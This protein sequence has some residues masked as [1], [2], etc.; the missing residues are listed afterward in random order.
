[1]PSRNYRRNSNPF[2]RPNTRG[3]TGWVYVIS[4]V[5]MPGMVKV[6]FTLN[7]PDVRAKGLGHTG[8]PHPY[9]VDYCVQVVDPYSVE[10]RAHQI[11][12]E[13][14]HRV[15]EGRAAGQGIEWFSCEPEEA[16]VAIRHSTGDE[17]KHESF[18]RAEREIVEANYQ[19]EKARLGAMA[20]VAERRARIGSEFRGAVLTAFPS[21]PY[22]E[23]FITCYPVAFAALAFFSER[24]KTAQILFTSVF[25]GALAALILQIMRQDRH[26]KSPKYLA[27]KAKHD[28]DIETAN[29]HFFGCP[30][31]SASMKIDYV[32][33]FAEGN[34]IKFHCKSCG[35]DVANPLAPP[36]A[37]PAIETDSR[38]SAI[39]DP[40]SASVL[41]QEPHLSRKATK[42]AEHL[43]PADQA[44]LHMIESSLKRS[45]QM[46]YR[47]DKPADADRSNVAD[48][49]P[50][51]PAI[52]QPA[53]KSSPLRSALLLVWDSDV[54]NNTMRQDL[55][56]SFQAGLGVEL[57]TRIAVSEAQKERIARASNRI[58]ENRSAKYEKALWLELDDAVGAALPRERWWGR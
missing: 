34:R 47:H 30:N 55:W 45:A 2:H 25:L 40:Q 4:N 21:W 41:P 10:Q 26:L 38:G 15:G 8:N 37:L 58:W 17:Y 33:S 49:S 6:G 23:Y 31:C 36:L 7:D 22:W 14:G 18:R 11:L 42:I 51:L 28:N 56:H 5:G 52:D 57:S 50:L 13:L 46:D 9:T 35:K 39:S 20:H 19:R 12:S 32:E 1:M 43:H 16:I 29:L 24:M 48:L 3:V 44:I 27:L 54:G 53:A